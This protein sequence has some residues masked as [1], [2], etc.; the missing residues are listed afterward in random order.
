MVLIITVINSCRNRFLKNKNSL[1]P[2]PV[3]D[4]VESNRGISSPIPSTSTALQS[5]SAKCSSPSPHRSTNYSIVEENTEEIMTPT[6]SPNNSTVR[7][8]A[9]KDDENER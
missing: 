1:Q 8:D 4:N 3:I 5:T 9:K 2:K 7:E 6:L